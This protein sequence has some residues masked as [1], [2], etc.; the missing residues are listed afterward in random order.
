MSVIIPVVNEAKLLPDFIA[1]LCA[2]D[3]GKKLEII[4]VDGKSA[5]DSVEIALSCGV[6]E[7]TKP[8]LSKRTY[9]K[10]LMASMKNS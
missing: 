2:Q 6:E 7:G 3:V 1:F 4:V 8:C 5:D 9:S 10:S